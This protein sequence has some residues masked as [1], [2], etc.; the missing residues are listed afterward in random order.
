MKTIICIL[1]PI[2]SAGLVWLL[3]GFC[4]W[5]L[6]LSE[7]EPI[8]RF[9]IIIIWL[10]ATIIPYAIMDIKGMFDKEK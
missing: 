4:R 2:A 6:D 8:D 3:T 7:L 1:T 10:M 9:G 5:N